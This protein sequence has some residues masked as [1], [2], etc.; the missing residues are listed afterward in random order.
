MAAFLGP[1]RTS[2]FLKNAGHVVWILVN[3]Q[4]KAVS[5]PLL[6]SLIPPGEQ[7]Y[8][9]VVC[10]FGFQLIIIVAICHSYGRGPFPFENHPLPRRDDVLSKLLDLHS[11]DTTWRKSSKSD[12]DRNW[13]RLLLQN[14]RISC[15]I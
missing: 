2:S 5:E 4:Y 14:L 6:T 8:Q 11:A 15:D 3:Q 10:A 12:T 1:C 9:H 13:E 7:D